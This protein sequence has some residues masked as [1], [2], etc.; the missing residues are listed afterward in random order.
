MLFVGCTAASSQTSMP[1]A[2]VP[3]TAI[4]TMQG[5]RQKA[6]TLLHS[7]AGHR[8]MLARDSKPG[9]YRDG[10]YLVTS[11]LSWI[12]VITHQS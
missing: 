1:V 8:Q 4:S 3:C 2:G 5:C 6:L 7:Q 11:N 12:S 9:A 10:L